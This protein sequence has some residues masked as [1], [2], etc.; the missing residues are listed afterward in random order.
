M[1]R[2]HGPDPRSSL[3]Q[4]GQIKVRGPSVLE[5]VFHSGMANVP[6]SATIAVRGEGAGC[7]TTPCA[8]IAT[9]ASALNGAGQPT[10]ANAAPSST[11]NSDHQTARTREGSRFR[12]NARAYSLD[13]FCGGGICGLI[14]P[15]KIRV[16]LGIRQLENP[17]EHRDFCVRESRGR[18]I[19]KRE[20]Q[21]VELP[22]APPAPPA[23]AGSSSVHRVELRRK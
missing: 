7:R 20:Q 23:Q 2:G 18:A 21:R 1:S 11:C 16:Q 3:A 13:D 22:H 8:T 19:D 6:P 10:R 12:T 17:L 9:I 14:T 15:E 5:P 4:N